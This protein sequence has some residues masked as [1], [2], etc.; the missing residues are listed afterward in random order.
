MKKALALVALVL[1]VGA[2]AATAQAR[3]PVG[4]QPP[5]SRPQDPDFAGQPCYSPGQVLYNTSAQPGFRP[6]Y[7]CS[8]TGQ[9]PGGWYF[10][11]VG[12]Y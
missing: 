3:L 6:I 8:Y 4:H 9:P 7:R 5:P 2:G 12:Y 1:S 11:I 10:L